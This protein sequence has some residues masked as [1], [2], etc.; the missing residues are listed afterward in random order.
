MVT[1]D[2]NRISLAPT[3]DLLA[4]VLPT[5]RLFG[6]GKAKPGTNP[7]LRTIDNR[8]NGLAIVS[9]Y[10][11]IFGSWALVAWLNHP[12]AW[13]V[14]LIWSAR[15]ISLLNLL[16]HEGV[17]ALLFSD[18]RWNDNVA[19]FLL[20]PVAITDFDAYRRAHLAH[21]KDELGPEEPD[22]SMYAPYPSGGWRLLRRLARDL[23]GISGAK[24]LLLLG[25]ASWTIRCRIVGAQLV[26]FGLAF[27]ITG[28]WWAWVL[29]WFVPWLTTWQ[30]TN[31][32]RAIAE[33][34]GMERG[35]D[36]RVTTHV[37]KSG[38]VSSFMLAPYQAGFHLAHHVDTSVPW[39][40]LKALNTELEQAG[41]IT[42]E[43]THAS[44]R[45]LWRYLASGERVSIPIP[46]G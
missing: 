15:C 33:H 28:Q 5:D 39:N 40:Q 4:D 12:L 9:V 19:R 10:A 36:R 41:W 45:D 2:H 23:A 18:R 26:I 44:Y 27:A 8:R 14:L 21:H 22:V 29:A 16:N 43:F 35:A 32:L 20:A 7:G 42:A 38:L 13:L 31:R 34:G 25:G 6:S 30:L 24:L 17:H 1:T 46:V 3:A 37:V 11:Q